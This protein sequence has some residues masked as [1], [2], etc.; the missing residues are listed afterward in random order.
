MHVVAPVVPMAVLRKNVHFNTSI[1]SS[2]FGRDW[3]FILL[4]VASN[5]SSN[6]FGIVLSAARRFLIVVWSKT[7]SIWR[8]VTRT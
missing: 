2:D 3:A 8:G 1:A 7:V 5:A 4:M 6:P